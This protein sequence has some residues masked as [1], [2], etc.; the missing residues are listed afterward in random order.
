VHLIIAKYSDEAERKRIEYAMERWGQVMKLGRPE[1]V[2][3]IIEDESEKVK[4]LLDDL[5]AR[6]S[7]DKIKIYALSQASFDV[8]KTEKEIKAA[9][10]GGMETVEKFI[11]F[12]LAKQKALFMR[13]IPF[14]KLYEVYTKKGR[15]EVAIGLKEEKGKVVVA[16]RITGFGD[17]ADL[18]YDKINSELKYF[19]EV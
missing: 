17:A 9:L 3:I 11:G 18:I 8:K 7:K 12:I 13:E 5:Y 10:E 15:A 6:T 16:I 1:G 2:P 4:E 14:G 19:K